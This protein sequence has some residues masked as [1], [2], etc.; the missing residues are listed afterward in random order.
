MRRASC[1]SQL[2]TQRSILFRVRCSSDG[3]A[4]EKLS[5]IDDFVLTEG[6]LIGPDF[7]IDRDRQTL[8]S[9]HT[10]AAHALPPLDPAL[11]RGVHVR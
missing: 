8:R 10:G 11:V 7:I 1:A 3:P 5:Q 6:A 2:L 4:I 9:I